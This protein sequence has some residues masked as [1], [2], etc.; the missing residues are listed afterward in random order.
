MLTTTGPLELG[1][2]GTLVVL[3][4]L[5][6]QA[7]YIPLFVKGMVTVTVYASPGASVVLLGTAVTVPVGVA[8]WQLEHVLL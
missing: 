7:P 2:A 1:P 6:I 3:P 8:L 5:W 4:E